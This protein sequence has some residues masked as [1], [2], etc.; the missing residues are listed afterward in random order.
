M[1]I[2]E[3]VLEHKTKL[4]NF[5]KKENDGTNH[6]H[7]IPYKDYRDLFK[8]KDIIKTG[9]KY[10]LEVCRAIDLPYTYKEEYNTHK[11]QGGV[12]MYY[13]NKK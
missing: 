11:Q 1:N 8:T 12:C 4:D 7:F 3:F 13:P 10:G 2:D 9:K 6:Q 5:I